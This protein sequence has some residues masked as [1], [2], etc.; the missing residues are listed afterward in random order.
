MPRTLHARRVV[1]PL[2]PSLPSISCINNDTSQTA[3]VLRRQKRAVVNSVCLVFDECCNRDC[4][5]SSK[6][7]VV[8]TITIR[9][10]R[11]VVCASG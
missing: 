3:G 4:E 7:I 9:S 6:A 10:H 2:A 5:G 11:L 8:I 1:F